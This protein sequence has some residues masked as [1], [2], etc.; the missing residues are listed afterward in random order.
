MRYVADCVKIPYPEGDVPA[1]TGVCRDEVIRAFRTLGVDLQKEVHEDRAQ[2]FSS[3]PHPIKRLALHPDANIDH[4]RVPN[5]MVF[6]SR[7]GESLP[8]THRAEDYAPGELVT[9]DLGGECAAYRDRSRPEITLKW[10]PHD[11]PQHRPGSQ[12]GGR[13]VCLEDHGALPVLRTESEDR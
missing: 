3:Y 6:F 8:I 12:N 9:W 7:K 10:T 2:S 4:R 1:D 11:C 13:F 5:L